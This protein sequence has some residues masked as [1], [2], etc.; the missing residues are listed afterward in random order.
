MNFTGFDI[1]DDA[2]FTFTCIPE[3]TRTALNPAGT[4]TN[5]SGTPSV[6]VVLV[7]P[8]RVA[9]SLVYPAA[10]TEGNMSL[11]LLS[12]GVFQLTITGLIVGSDPTNARRYAGHW[13]SFGAAKGGGS[14][15][16]TVIDPSPVSSALLVPA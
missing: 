11:V 14:F 6:I 7:D 8:N 10:S 12:Q 16:F 13:A 9:T 2:V 3:S 5:P 4:P 15:A 1:N